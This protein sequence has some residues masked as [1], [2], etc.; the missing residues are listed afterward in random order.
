MKN[1]C[2]MAIAFLLAVICVTAGVQAAIAKSFPVGGKIEF[3][4]STLDTRNFACYSSGEAGMEIREGKLFAPARTVTKAA[5]YT[6]AYEDVTVSVDITSVIQKGRL[7]SGIILAGSNF[8]NGMDSFTGWV[9]NVEREIG[10]QACDVRLHRFDH[11]PCAVRRTASAR[12]Q[13]LPD[14]RHGQLRFP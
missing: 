14:S 4:F 5:Y 7:D 6:Q 8:G 9:V 13:N 3:E 12:Q 10:A 11:F 2:Y 1:R